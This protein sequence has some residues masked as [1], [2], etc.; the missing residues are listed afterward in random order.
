MTPD[1]LFDWLRQRMRSIGKSVETLHTE[2]LW[3]GEHVCVFQIRERDG[4][5][6]AFIWRKRQ[7]RE[8]MG[9]P[10]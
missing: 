7:Q 5:L 6:H 1:S 10:K 4:Q 9:W 3:Y 2:L 8:A